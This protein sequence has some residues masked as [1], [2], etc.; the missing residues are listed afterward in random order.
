MKAATL[1]LIL[2][3][4]S[5]CKSAPKDFPKVPEFTFKQA[6]I[7]QVLCN[8]QKTDCKVVSVC[9]VVDRESGKILAEHPI[10][11][12]HGIIGVNSKEFIS[13]KDFIRRA[14]IW[15]E[16]AQQTMSKE[17]LEMVNDGL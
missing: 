10:K 1:L 12:C 3:S 6:I 15:I 4:F 2:L 7:E 16:R 14:Q 17:V 8:D 13:I 9:R 11:F 5:A